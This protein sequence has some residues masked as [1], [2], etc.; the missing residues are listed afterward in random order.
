[1]KHRLILFLLATIAYAATPVD[2]E[3]QRVQTLIATHRS[4]L[5]RLNAAASAVSQNLVSG[6]TYYICC[7][8]NAINSEVYGRAGGS[9]GVVVYSGQQIGTKDVLW[10]NYTSGTY[11]SV[12]TSIAQLNV[13]QGAVVV[14]FGPQPPTGPPGTYWID[15]LTSWADDDAFALM[16]NVLSWWS[17]TGELAAATAR[18]GKTLVFWESVQPPGAAIR[19]SH[20][21][22]QLFHNGWPQM[23][24][25]I[26]A[27]TLAGS[28]LDYAGTMVGQIVQAELSK[29][30]ATG[31]L[32]AQRKTAGT[33]V[34]LGINSHLVRILAAAG[35]PYFQYLDLNGTTP[36][37]SLLSSNGYLVSLDYFGVNLDSW[38][39][40]RN[41][42]GAN[43]TWIN[44]ASSHQADFTPYGDTIITQ[45][46]EFGDSVVP[47]PGYDVALLPVSGVAQLFIYD[48]L[49][50]AAAN[51]AGSP[52][53]TVSITT[54]S[55]NTTVSNGSVV[56]SATASAATGL[57]IATIQ[58]KVDG[59]A[60]GTPCT[61]SP[62]NVTLNTAALTN[63]PHS[64][65]ATATDSAG[66]VANSQPVSIT[67]SNTGATVSI[68]APAAGATVT[69]GSVQVTATATA[70]TGQTL[71]SIQL[72][73]DGS[74][75]GTA[76][77]TSPCSATLNTAV[78]ANA[79]HSLTAIATDSASAST[80]SAAV[81][82][83]VT[84]GPT[85]S[86]TAPAAGATVTTGSVQVTATATAPTGQTLASIQLKVDGSNFG[87]ACTT[88]PC[89]ATLNTTLLTIGAHS[90]TAVAT[91]SASSSATSAAVAIT[92]NAPQPSVPLITGFTTGT[93]RNNFGSFVGMQ[94]TVGS[95][96]L[97]VTSLGRIYVAGN[98]GSHILKL[99]RVSD[100]VDVPGASV[101]VT[102]STGTAGQF[103]Y[104]TLPNPVTLAA[105]TSYYLVSQ[106]ALNGDR[107]Y[108]YTPITSTNVVSINGP[109]YA[110]G[111]GWA[112]LGFTGYSYVPVSL[113]Y[114]T[115]ASTT[116]PTASVTS[117][118]ANS[119]LSGSAVTVTATASAAS[120]LTIASLQLKV[121]GASFGSAC[122]TSPC[123]ATLNTTTL[124]NGSHN[125]TA[126]ATDSVNSTTTSAAVT[127]TVSNT[128]TPPPNGNPLITTQTL[129]TPRNNY[130]GF[131][132]MRFQ[133]GS[134][135]MTIG[136]LG[137]ICLSGNA[138]THTVKLVKTDGTDLVNGSVS[139]SMA[140]C[141]P[142]Q[143]TYQTLATAVTLAANTAYYLVSQ[144][145]SG[146]DQWY[147][148]SPVTPSAAATI[149]G[150]VYFAGSY[151]VVA[152]P[153]Y[154][155]V[156]VNLLYQ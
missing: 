108:D 43:A 26:Q 77:T 115:G 145:T 96:G 118:A 12:S 46:W 133:A 125:L 5:T 84:N 16:G 105:A 65:T 135:N 110:N 137:R 101:T 90:L 124:S 104:A 89:T 28:Y 83:T 44:A 98:N 120:G 82:I 62:C 9:M 33:A 37:S 74:N 22:N 57:T 103:T 32:M 152:A 146:G 114:T 75:F 143:Y 138:G 56:V 17:L 154:S 7:G 47:V 41:T 51:T 130:T 21:T 70:P 18:Q 99:V 144:E 73:V 29:I 14:W 128:V 13:P 141:S 155:Y 95:T 97:S 19:N 78:L 107:W 76:C 100:G 6:G 81:S 142:G 91:G 88:S 139:I 53:P 8:D 85:V 31:Q 1:M 134:S 113:L 127:V 71:A 25:T 61:S 112:P 140:G 3:V 156:P 93:L 50:R 117:P 20:Y 15:S 79:S 27:G 129:G 116:P 2:S 30:V 63:G 10:V 87:T 66:T 59:S 11:Q 147:D 148:Y 92:V 54:P 58:T 126:V 48:L 24:A 35:S 109:V 49:L 106:E 34:I 4:S 45:H 153:G 119:T 131:V 80:T 42:A 40:V 150:P 94:F 52:P 68:T 151:F 111:T 149:S 86:I 39:T 72:K 69:T 36:L 55:S 64:I 60:F 38:R 122:A 121:D 102:P 136:S 132:G 23:A 67:V 123:S